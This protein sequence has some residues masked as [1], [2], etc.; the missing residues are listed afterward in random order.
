MA[1]VVDPLKSD[2]FNL[3]NKISRQHGE[4]GRQDEPESSVLGYIGNQR[5]VQGPG[6]PWPVR[7]SWRNG[8]TDTYAGPKQCGTPVRHSGTISR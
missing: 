3:G 8:P 7:H 6:N 1:L 5:S 2:G 4:A